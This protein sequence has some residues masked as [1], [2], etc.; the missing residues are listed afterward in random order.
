MAAAGVIGRGG[1]RWA[2]GRSA[3]VVAGG[4]SRWEGPQA[5]GLA[6][7]ARMARGAMRMAREAGALERAEAMRMAR[8]AGAL[9][10]ADGRVVSL[11]EAGRRWR[12]ARA[13]EARWYIVEAVEGKDFEVCLQIA[14]T[15]WDCWRPVIEVRATRRCKAHGVEQTAS[16]VRKQSV[17]GR[18]VFLHECLTASMR[19]LIE[20]SPKVKGFLCFA[21]SE[22]PATVPDDV[23]AFYRKAL[24]GKRSGDL[25]ARFDIELTDRVRISRGPANGRIGVVL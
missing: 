11:A 14:A 25:A 12:E 19:V 3:R 8:E 1:A 23:I 16:V 9:E 22:A 5:V 13:S 7:S 4:V 15:G 18:Y 17:F 21:G 20:Q 10:R 2:G 24:E 6:H